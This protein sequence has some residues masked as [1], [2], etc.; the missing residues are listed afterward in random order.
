MKNLDYIKL[1]LGSVS[2]NT[3]IL[4]NKQT[5]E[6]I[7]IDPADEA[8]KIIETIEENALK[9]QA[10]LLTHGHFDHILAADDVKKHYNIKVYGYEKER[11]LFE[12][13][14]KNTSERFLR[15]KVKVDIDEYFNDDNNLEFLGE[16]F[17]V[18]HTPGHTKGSVC[19]YLKDEELLIAGDT[20][21]Y[22]TYGRCDLYSG[23]HDDMIASLAKLFLLDDNILVLP[24]H[25]RET[26]IGD[27][28]KYNYILRY[29]PKAEGK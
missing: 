27:E 11:E 8:K 6:C 3:Y 19:F 22:H 9:P 17:E 23:N 12:D 20:L 1:V 29:F 14:S 7:I 5:K 26:N 28:K 10:I 21:F 16:K 15:K 18:I 2:T 13:S 4:Y 25:E 24:G